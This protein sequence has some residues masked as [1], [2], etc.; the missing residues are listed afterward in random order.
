MALKLGR[1]EPEPIKPAWFVKRQGERQL[2]PSDNERL[3]ILKLE[4]GCPRTEPVPRPLPSPPAW[5]ARP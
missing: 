2:Q 5:C 1:F 4:M 3:K